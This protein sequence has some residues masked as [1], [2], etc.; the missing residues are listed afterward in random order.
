MGGEDITRLS[1]AERAARRRRVIGAVLQRHNLHPL[2]DAAAN[3]ALPLRLDGRPRREIR[4]RVEELLEYVGQCAPALIIA[5]RS[6]KS[7][8]TTGVSRSVRAASSS[9]W[10]T[11][12]ARPAASSLAGS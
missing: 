9:M 12:W 3:I 10:R 7:A 6:W 2:L 8:C 1:A 5:S 11:R 4:A